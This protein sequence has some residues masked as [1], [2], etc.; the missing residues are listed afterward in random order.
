MGINKPGGL[1][2][3]TFLCPWLYRLVLESFSKLLS[4]SK[5]SMKYH[6]LTEE[7]EGGFSLSHEK[8]RVERYL[9]KEPAVVRGQR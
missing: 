6:S 7:P 8:L 2:R 1:P 9:V 3:T 5:R 4:R